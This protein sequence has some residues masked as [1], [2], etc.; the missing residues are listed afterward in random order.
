MQDLVAGCDVAVGNEEDAEKVFGI[1]R[2][3]RMSRAAK[4]RPGNIASSA[5]SWPSASRT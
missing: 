1:T 2:P 3:R 5:R 4:S